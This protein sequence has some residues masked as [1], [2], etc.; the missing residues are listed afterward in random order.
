LVYTEE[1]LSIKMMALNKTMKA[2][3]DLAAFARSG[4][5]GGGGDRVRICYSVG[6]VIKLYS[7]DVNIIF[8]KF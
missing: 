4:A 3:A 6:N 2:R 7:F 5:L 1:I 8:W